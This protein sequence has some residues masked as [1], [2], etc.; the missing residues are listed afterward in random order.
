[1]KIFSYIVA[2]ILIFLGISFSLI[3]AKPVE[4]NYYIGTVQISLSLLLILTVGLG[5]LI[6]FIVSLAPMLRL[7]RK[8]HQL[9]NRIRQLEHNIVATKIPE[10]APVEPG[11]INP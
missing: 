1:M 2:I 9:K 6:G 5:I 3:N 7:K 10:E 4:L 8:N 11:K